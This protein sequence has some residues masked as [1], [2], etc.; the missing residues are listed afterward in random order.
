[1]YH[2]DMLTQLFT[3]LAIQESET[4]HLHMP[5]GDDFTR[6]QSLHIMLRDRRQPSLLADADFANDIPGTVDASER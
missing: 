1:M 6:F 5:F 4:K 2:S 3:A